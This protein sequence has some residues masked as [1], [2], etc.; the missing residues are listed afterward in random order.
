[1]VGTAEQKC[2]QF[3]FRAMIQSTDDNT[4]QCNTEKD[5]DVRLNHH[6]AGYVQPSV[7]TIQYVRVTLHFIVQAF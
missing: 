1:M 3:I 5:K 7:M 6:T 4:L 2:M